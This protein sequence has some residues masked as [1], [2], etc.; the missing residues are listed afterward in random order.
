MLPSM[1]VGV[2]WVCLSVRKGSNPPRVI[3]IGSNGETSFEKAMHDRLNATPD[4]FDFSLTDQLREAM[5]A[6]DF[7][8]FHNA[9]LVGSAARAKYGSLRMY[10]VPQIM[11][12]LN[13]S[14]VD[15]FKVDCESCEREVVRDLVR[16][17]T[18]ETVPFGQIQMEIHDVEDGPGGAIHDVK[19]MLLSLEELGYRMFHVELNSRYLQGFEAAFIHESLVKP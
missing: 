14:Y 16:V 18:R 10:T 13:Q 4:V 2:Q 11:R 3:S 19:D 15:V 9:G 7:L 17:Y 1:H 5:G 12:V 8:R 6:Y